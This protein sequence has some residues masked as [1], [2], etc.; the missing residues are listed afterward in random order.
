MSDKTIGF[1]VLGAAVAYVLW[2]RNKQV[3][4]SSPDSEEYVNSL[5]GDTFAAD[6]NLHVL[7]CAQT[8][9]LQYRVGN[10]Q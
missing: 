3:D 5:N 6:P 1:L 4:F 2:N 10:G 7:P 8:L 9:S